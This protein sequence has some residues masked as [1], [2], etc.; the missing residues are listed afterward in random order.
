[1]SDA[2]E[3][4][5]A[6][7][8]PREIA[9]EHLSKAY[10]RAV[11]AQ[12]GLT[13]E[14]PEYDDGIDC[15]IGTSKACRV[16]A[17]RNVF[18]RFQLKS[19]SSWSVQNGVVAYDLDKDN[20]N[21]LVTDSNMPQYLGLFLVPRMRS[22]WCTAHSRRCVV[23]TCMLFMSLRGFEPTTNAATKR[24]ALNAGQIL[25]APTLIAMVRDAARQATGRST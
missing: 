17:V 7:A 12:A 19:T 4:S 6:D 5:F 13:Y 16:T 9:Q 2:T 8:I 18:V 22:L 3:H 15:Q 25:T 1:M 10:L 14:E 21:Q 20:Y 11:A 24:V 23:R